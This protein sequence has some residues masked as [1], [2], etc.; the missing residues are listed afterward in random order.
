VTVVGALTP[1]R[2]ADIPLD[3]TGQYVSTNLLSVLYL[4]Q[5]ALPYLRKAKGR[6]VLVSSG[7]SAAGYTSWGLYSMVKAG[8][9]SLARTLA[10]EEKELSVWAIRPGMVD[11]S[12]QMG[13]WL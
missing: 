10:N 1:A 5:P 13:V 7:A 3:K 12:A 6:V 2:I 4:V 11:V 9:N 8:M